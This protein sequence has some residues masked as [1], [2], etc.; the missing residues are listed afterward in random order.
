MAHSQAASRF[1]ARLFTN[2]PVGVTVQGPA[3]KHTFRLAVNPEKKGHIWAIAHQN[4]TRRR[5]RK[6][7]PRLPLRNRRSSRRWRPS[8]PPNSSSLVSAAF[9]A[10][11]AGEAVVGPRPGNGLVLASGILRRLLISRVPIQHSAIPSRAWGVA[12]WREYYS[13][14]GAQQDASAGDVESS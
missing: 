10:L 3:E 7:R 13:G 6:S 9:P 1:A 5:P 11:R 4:Q 14:G 2:H 12:R 8:S